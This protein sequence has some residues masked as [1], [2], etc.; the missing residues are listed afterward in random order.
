MCQEPAGV[1]QR[2]HWASLLTFAG[3]RQPGEEALGFLDVSLF[4][5]CLS[6]ALQFLTTSTAVPP[7]SGWASPAWLRRAQPLKGLS[8]AWPSA[9]PSQRTSRS[10]ALRVKTSGTVS[11]F[12]TAGLLCLD[13]Q[14]MQGWSLGYTDPDTL[15]CYS[16]SS[17]AFQKAGAWVRGLDQT[18]AVRTGTCTHTPLLVSRASA[19]PPR[20][21]CSQPLALCQTPTPSTVS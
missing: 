6:A 11:S 17:L 19:P 21:L 7:R 4:W 9:W 13:G 20:P 10:S 1:R 16:D 14:Q 12:P 15:S 3:W 18:Q 8:T 2:T 5:T